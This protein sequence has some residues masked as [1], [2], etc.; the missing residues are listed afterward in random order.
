MTPCNHG[1]RICL[2]LRMTTAFATKSSTMLRYARCTSE[3][4]Q[5]TFMT[6]PFLSC[7][8]LRACSPSQPPTTLRTSCRQLSAP[9][10]S[11]ELRESGFS[12]EPSCTT[13]EIPDS[14]LAILA[15]T[16]V[17]GLAS[18]SEIEADAV[19]LVFPRA[20]FALQTNTLCLPRVPRVCLVQFPTYR[21]LGWQLVLHVL[22]YRAVCTCQ[23][24]L[25]QCINRGDV[26]NIE[27]ACF[28]RKGVS[29]LLHG[30]A[31]ACNVYFRGLRLTAVKTF[32]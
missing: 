29:I 7:C 30:L 2:S 4:T 10:S 24:R 32:R 6:S 20:W 21:S 26:C 9:Q 31:V 28:E 12:Y 22:A 19:A 5:S 15:Q 16:S 8:C 25:L 18:A 1:C 11:L 13:C 17:S 27:A 14:C 23:L 3:L